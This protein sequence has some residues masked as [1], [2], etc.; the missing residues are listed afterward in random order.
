MSMIL[1]QDGIFLFLLIGLSIPLDIYIYK[2]MTGQKVFMTRLLAPAEKGIYRMMGI[3]E[4]TEMSAKKYAVSALVFSG[5]GLLLLFLI[6]LIQNIL[7][8]NPE[9]L[10]SV[11][12]DLAFNTAVSF[13][14]NTNWQAYSGESTLSYFT[15]SIGLTVQNFLS[16][17]VGI[18]ILFALIRGFTSKNKNN[19]LLLA[20]FNT[21]CFIH[22]TASFI[23]FSSR[24]SI[25]RRCPDNFTLQRCNYIA[26]R[27]FTDNTVRSCRKPNCYKTTW[28]Q[29]RWF[30][31]NEFCI[32][33]GKPYGSFEFITAF[34]HT[35][36]SFCSLYCFRKSGKKFKARQNHF[37]DYVDSVRCISNNCYCQRTI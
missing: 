23:Y 15:Q 34:I 32:S 27:R 16:A 26:K 31:W 28:H 21:F 11:K 33:S 14:T 17:G 13:I 35:A 22:L 36:N 7:P 9:H 37:S 19:R 25:T 20:R 1:L 24:F 6:Q 29:R 3:H 5:I 18:A 12:W 10:G 4:E 30:L 8:L 2:V